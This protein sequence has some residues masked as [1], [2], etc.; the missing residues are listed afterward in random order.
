MDRKDKSWETTKVGRQTAL[1]NEEE[2][3]LKYYINYMASINH[4]L[5]IPAVKA[6]AW[7]ITKKSDCPNG[8]NL[9]TGPGDKWFRNFKKRQNL[10]NRK[11][12]K[13]D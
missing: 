8:F 12:D 2:T 7:A 13:V 4:P 10:T 11:P 6:F 9:Q 1:S 3:S 5:S